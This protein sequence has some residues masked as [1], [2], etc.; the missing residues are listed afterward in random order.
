MNNLFK[1]ASVLPGIN[2]SSK[3][4]PQ[5]LELNGNSITLSCEAE[6]KPAPSIAWVKDGRVV[7]NTTNETTLVVSEKG[8]YECRVSNIAGNDSYRV[9]VVGKGPGN[10]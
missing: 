7:K 10:V 4:N 3:P 6:G 5:D 1:N 8:T 2:D 9:S